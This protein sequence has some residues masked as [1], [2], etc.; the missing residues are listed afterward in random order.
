MHAEAQK[1]GIISTR[2]K[3]LHYC[4]SPDVGVGSPNSGPLKDLSPVV[5]T[6]EPFPVPRFYFLVAFT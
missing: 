1:E 5:L 3:A 4:E 2:A 6:A